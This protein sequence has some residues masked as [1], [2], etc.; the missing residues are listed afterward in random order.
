MRLHATLASL[1]LIAAAHS[2]LHGET[3][4]LTNGTSVDGEIISRTERGVTIRTASGIMTL[5]MARIVRIEESAPGAMEFQRAEEAFRTGRLKESE[6]LFQ[7]A[8]EA[9]AD[10]DKVSERLAQ[11]LERRAGE[12]LR[13]HG[14]ALKEAQDARAKGEYT[15]AETAYRSLLDLLSD[16]SA[17]R[18]VVMDELSDMHISRG[19]HFRDTV[20][21]SAAIVEFNK[22]LALKPD[23]GDA[24]IALGLLYAKSSRTRDEAIKNLRR[25][26]EL[27]EESME[28]KE[29]AT[30]RYRL[31][32]LYRELGNHLAAFEEYRIVHQTGV[33]NQDP[34][35]EPTLLDCCVRAAMELAQRDPVAATA[36]L[37][38]G[39]EVRMTPQLLVARAQI[40][41][42]RGESEKAIQTY[43]QVIAIDPSLKN[44][45]YEVS[46]LYLRMLRTADARRHLERE[47]EVW[48]ENYQALC[49]LGDLAVQRDDIEGAENYYRLANQVDDDRPRAQLGLAR[50]SRRLNKIAEARRF[51]DEVLARRPSDVYANLEKGFI[52]RE[53]EKNSGRDTA[54]AIFSEVLRLIPND[55]ELNE[56]QRKRVIADAYLARGEIRLLTTGP[57]TANN[58]FNAALQSFPNYPSA[59]YNIGLAY[60]QKYTLSKDIQD[61]QEAE[62]NLLRARELDPGNPIYALE[63]GILYH[64]SF[65]QVDQEN[66]ASHLFRAAQSYQ[67]YIDLGGANAA[68]VRQWI[69]ECQ[70]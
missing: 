57:N 27:S 63:L 52:V 68:T 69:R 70:G 31:A 33:M 32:D 55:L 49:D 6:A 65:A 51:V 53:E 12:E 50:T 29:S 58:D 17:L 28:T 3:I 11:I 7:R 54:S 35:I 16:G 64:Q 19:E 47:V 21:D 20:N 41:V 66:K 15:K 5:P 34:R 37:D 43:E 45:N 9:G 18:I 25:G 46:Q 14:P 13:I 42:A 59:F 62:E 1:A 60:R 40:E 26:L 67:R 44:M 39:I 4:H 8:L 24:Y 48:P 10:E 38:K 22:A 56:E 23:Q 61:L 36:I 2:T 30:L